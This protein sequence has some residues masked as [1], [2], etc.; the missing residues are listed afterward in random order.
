MQVMNVNK[1]AKCIGP[2]NI[3]DKNVYVSSNYG[4]VMN[5]T[6]QNS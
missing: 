1:Y 6:S 4:N 3:V 2:T 5:K